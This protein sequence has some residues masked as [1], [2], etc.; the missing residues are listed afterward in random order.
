MFMNDSFRVFEIIYNTMPNNNNLFPVKE[1]CGIAGV[2]RS[3]Y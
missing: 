1:L 2:P 3:G